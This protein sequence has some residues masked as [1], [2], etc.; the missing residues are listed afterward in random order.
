MPSWQLCSV[1]S[2]SSLLIVRFHRFGKAVSSPED[3][4]VC[5]RKD[6]S[7]A[8]SCPYKTRGVFCTERCKCLATDKNC[9]NQVGFYIPFHLLLTSVASVVFRIIQLKWMTILMCSRRFHWIVPISTI[10][11]WSKCIVLIQSTSHIPLVTIYFV[12][13]RSPIFHVLWI[14][15]RNQT[16]H[17]APFQ[18]DRLSLSTSRASRDRPADLPWRRF[19]DSIANHDVDFKKITALNQP[20]QVLSI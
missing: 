1:L 10:S 4:G 7:K 20:F 16:R 13:S 14:R 18:I 6:G 19:R 2:T 9:Q 15:L 3:N 8:K 5:S 12:L 17:L 11:C